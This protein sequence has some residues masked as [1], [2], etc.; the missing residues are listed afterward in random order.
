MNMKQ[1]SR[2]LTFGALLGIAAL[3]SPVL[4]ADGDAMAT[5]AEIMKMANKDGMISKKDFMAMMEK[6]F[7]E[8]DK[9]KKGMLSTDDVMRIYGRSDKGQ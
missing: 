6:K 3:S 9:S 2:N 1:A 5:R 8:M 4:A 7:D